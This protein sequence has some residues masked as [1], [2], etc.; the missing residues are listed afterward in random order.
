MVV[1]SKGS[2]IPLYEGGQV[3]RSCHDAKKIGDIKA[4]LGVV[5]AA[6]M[7]TRSKVQ[8]QSMILLMITP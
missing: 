2:C 7:R 5:K 3:D 8:V 4:M 1:A 6:I